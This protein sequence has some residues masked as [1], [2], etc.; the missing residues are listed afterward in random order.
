MADSQREIT[1]QLLESAL[2][3]MILQEG[4]NYDAALVKT[5][6]DKHLS[7]GI[8]AIYKYL[9]QLVKY[10]AEIKALI[11]RVIEINEAEGN[12][13]FWVTV[14]RYDSINAQPIATRGESVESHIEHLLSNGGAREEALKRL[15]PQYASIF[16]IRKSLSKDQVGMYEYYGGYSNDWTEEAFVEDGEDVTAFDLF[17]QKL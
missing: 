14:W 17:F 13:E 15:L 6:C 5:L 3:G 16:K 1:K 10:E 11:D 4:P 2:Q 12:T 8:D 7:P 9:D